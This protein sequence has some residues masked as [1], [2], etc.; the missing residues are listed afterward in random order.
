M[1]LALALIGLC[2][3]GGL[4]ALR[5][6]VRV[7]PNEAIV[8]TTSRGERAARFRKAGVW[9]FIDRSEVSLLDLCSLA[10]DGGRSYVSANNVELEI[11]LVVQFGFERNERAVLKAVSKQLP[12]S[13]ED[14]CAIVRP[15]IE[16]SMEI[17]TRKRT[18]EH[19]L[20]QAHEY[21]AAVIELSAP[22]MAEYGLTI[23]S[24]ILKEVSGRDGYIT[25][26]GKQAMERIRKQARERI[27]AMPGDQVSSE[28][29]FVETAVEQGFSRL[30]AESH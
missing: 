23:K 16:Q 14:R 22:A 28:T 12:N 21:S 5:R 27:D 6:T 17:V 11:K 15:L 2:M 24:A 7:S 9:R 1:E 29:E 10:L 30:M 3:L 8:I 19:I 20:N 26:L 18:A 4:V 25:R 13:L